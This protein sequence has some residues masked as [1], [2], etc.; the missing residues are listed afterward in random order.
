MARLFDNVVTGVNCDRH[1]YL[2]QGG[3]HYW[4][5]AP[6]SILSRCESPIVLKPLGYRTQRPFTGYANSLLA[7]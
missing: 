1:Q 7:V 3:D 2:A 5:G 6:A 4:V